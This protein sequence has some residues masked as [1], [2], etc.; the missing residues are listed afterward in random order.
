MVTDGEWTAATAAAEVAAARVARLPA[1]DALRAA[2]AAHQDLLEAGLEVERAVQRSN[3]AAALAAEAAT[4]EQRAVEVLA[5]A[6]GGH[7]QARQHFAAH[8]LAERLAVGDPCPVCGHE[9][10]AAVAIATPDDLGERRAAVDA[11]RGALDEA[12]ERHRRGEVAAERA[13]ATVEQ[14]RAQLVAL[15]HRLADHPDREAVEAQLTEAVAAQAAEAA[16]REAER[17][18]AGAAAAR[19]AEADELGRRASALGAGYHA[20]RDA[21]AALAPPVPG[22]DVLAAWAELERWAGEQRDLQ[23]VAVTGAE[24]MAAEVAGARSALLDGLVAAVGRAGVPAPTDGRAL[25]RAVVS[26]LATA[27]EQVASLERDVELAARLTAE[28]EAA[29]EERVVAAE[30]GRLLSARGFERWLVAE[31]LHR[32]A[33]GAS[34]TL[35]VLSGGQFSL[36]ID[37]D[38]EFAVVDHGNGDEL[39]PVRTLSGGE[40]FQASLA[41]ALALADELSGMASGGATKLD[42]IFLDEGFGTLDPESLDTVAATIESLGTGGRMVGIV[43]HVRELAARVPVRYEVR[44]G[45]TTSTVERVAG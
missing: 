44:K 3:E 36:V 11:A 5:E 41:L 28:R 12:R 37:A 4:A 8:L 15:E 21:V 33:E 30:L 23:V 26:A 1:L 45:P 27:T 18:C 43:T 10:L 17:A 19:R 32:L 2:A 24:A 16:A 29:G 7:E 40:T 13:A 9:V 35:H 20:Q 14:L 34:A 6:E 22:D 39:R 42:A 31:A 38:G 25:H